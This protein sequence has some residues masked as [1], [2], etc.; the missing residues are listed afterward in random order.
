MIK[1]ICSCCAA[2]ME[3]EGSAFYFPCI[4]GIEKYEKHQLCLSCHETLT[5]SYTDKLL[6]PMEGTIRPALYIST[7]TSNGFVDVRY[8]DNAAAQA[9]LKLLR[10]DHQH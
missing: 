6:K 9:T 3:V 1:A 4:A 2:V 10:L 7:P 8:V 5:T